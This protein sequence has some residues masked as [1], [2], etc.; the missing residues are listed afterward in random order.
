MRV[1]V[2]LRYAVEVYHYRGER[3]MVDGY[4]LKW[5]D[6]RGRYVAEHRLI[7]ESVLGRYLKSDEE[8][9]HVN[10]QRTDNRREN[11]V[12]C[13][14]SYHEYLDACM[15]LRHRGMTYRHRLKQK[16][17]IRSFF[18][19]GER[20]SSSQRAQVQRV[21][22]SLPIPRTQKGIPKRD[23]RSQSGEKSPK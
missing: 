4:W 17:T 21:L 8:V 5:D 18:R 16:R 12:L 6:A 1:S 10:G 23:G 15:R 11:F 19:S 7:C 20:L 3:I 13:N 14:P 22:D 9:H 2:D